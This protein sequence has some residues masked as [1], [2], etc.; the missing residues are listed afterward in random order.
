[1]SY[2]NIFGKQSLS[3][4]KPTTINIDNHQISFITLSLSSVN[5]QGNQGKYR[6]KKN[7]KDRSCSL[8]RTD[9][10]AEIFLIWIHIFIFIFLVGNSCRKFHQTAAA[11]RRTG[12]KS[13][14]VVNCCRKERKACVFLLWLWVKVWWSCSRKKHMLNLGCNLILWKESNYMLVQRKKYKI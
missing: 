12:Q 7:K 2:K 3:V 10:Y 5:I 13:G 8:T 4:C 6:H 9:R 11:E 14:H 1:M